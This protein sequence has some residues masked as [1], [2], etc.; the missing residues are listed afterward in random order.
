VGDAVS[1]NASRSHDPTSIPSSTRG[2]SPRGRERRR[3]A[4]E[5][6][7]KNFPTFTP[8]VPG[9]Y[10]ATLTVSDPFGGVATDSLVVSWSRVLSSR[11]PGGHGAQRR[12]RAGA[13]EVTTRGNQMRSSQFSPRSSPRSN[14]VTSTRPATS[15]ERRSNGPTGCALEKIPDGNGQGR[16]WVTDC[17]AQAS[18]YPPPS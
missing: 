3:L 4:G 12:R 17:A 8:D 13:G 5:T 1:L 14:P 11:E 16:D 6:N 2:R 18:L 10:I 9:S 7:R 15:Y